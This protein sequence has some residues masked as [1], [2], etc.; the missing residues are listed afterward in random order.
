[1]RLLL[2]LGEVP[3]GK[4]KLE[5]RFENNLN[6][7]AEGMRKSYSKQNEHDECKGTEI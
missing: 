4:I 6:L 1:M 5:M 2:T 3:F 7:P